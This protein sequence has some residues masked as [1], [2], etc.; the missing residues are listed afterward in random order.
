MPPDLSLRVRFC[1]LCGMAAPLLFAL[2]VGILGLLTPGYDPV[3][4][5]MSELAATGAPYAPA[6]NLLGFAATGILLV[7][8]SLGLRE[9]LGE[10]PAATAGPVLVALAGISYLA[11]AVFSCDPGCVPITPAGAIHLDVGLAATLIAI[12]SAFFLAWALWRTAGWEGF[13]RYSLV[14]GL[15]LV[16]VLPVFASAQDRAGLWQR[17]LVGILLLWVEVMAIRL[18][19]LWKPQPGGSPD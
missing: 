11:M 6:M 10:G 17:V 13:S 16:A 3:S 7:I 1:A 15:L 18:Y 14:T 12:L 2:T 8:F 5:L 19:L 4:Q 9:G